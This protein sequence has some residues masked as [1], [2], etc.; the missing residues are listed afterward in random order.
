MK[1]IINDCLYPK[2]ESLASHIREHLKVM[3]PEK[4]QKYE[5]DTRWNVWWRK[6]V[7]YIFL[8]VVLFKFPNLFRSDHY[9]VHL[10]LYVVTL[11]HA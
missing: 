1:E 8:Y 6:T 7:F 4:M 2:E 10:V 5:K 11:G 3:A 9:V